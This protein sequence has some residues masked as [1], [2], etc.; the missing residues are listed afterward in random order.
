MQFDL[1]LTCSPEFS[2]VFW[3][4]CAVGFGQM[5]SVRQRCR[6]HPKG[7]ATPSR[8]PVARTS[9]SASGAH[10]RSR[11]PREPLARHRPT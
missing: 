3:L 7:S 8:L 6:N 10:S 9:P 4:C 2:S 11:C 5:A 1:T